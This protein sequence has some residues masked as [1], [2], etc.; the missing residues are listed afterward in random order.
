MKRVALLAAFTLAGCGGG[1]PMIGVAGSGLSTV[2]SFGDNPGGLI[3]RRYV[4]TGVPPNAPLIVALHACGQDAAGFST[5]GLDPLADADKFY[6]VYPEQPSSN[7]SDQCFNW[8]GAYGFP[9]DKSNI[10]RGEGESESIKEMVDQMKADFSIDPARVFALGFSAGGAMA[11]V[12][13][14]DYPD[15][16]AAGG[17]ASGVPYDCPSLTVNDVYNCMSPGTTMAAADWGQKV[18]DADSSWSGPWPRVSIWQGTQDQ[19]VAFANSHELVKQW[20]NVHGISATPTRSDQVAG[21]PHDVYADRSGAIAVESY[22]ITGMDHFFPIDPAH[23]CGSNGPG[24][25]DEHLC[26]AQRMVSFFGIAA[27][28]APDAGVSAP[29]AGMTLD[30]GMIP[31]AADAGAE[32]DAM[33]PSGDTGSFED[34][35]AIASPDGGA[36]ISPDAGSESLPDAGAEIEPSDSGLASITPSGDRPVPQSSGCSATGATG[37]EVAPVLIALASL[38]LRL[39]RKRLT[40]R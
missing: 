23:G 32:L 37:G 10:T 13:L 6:V 40:A 15:I 35:G 30:A 16:F 4:P 21:F 5:S 12:L 14:A 38:R 8:Y 25:A 1:A 17:I 3:M 11:A 18:R 2:S 22:A 34:A 28:A 7:N 27:P 19:T 29:D 36:I 9:W 20:T 33:L 31:P 24:F 39:R 26:A